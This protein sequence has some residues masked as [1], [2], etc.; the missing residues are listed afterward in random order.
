MPIRTTDFLRYLARVSNIIYIVALNMESTCI[1]PLVG[2]NI[3]YNRNTPMQL[4]H[5]A[6][7]W[8]DN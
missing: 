3:D 5:L 7:L 1:A 6:K 8:A 2:V 4:N